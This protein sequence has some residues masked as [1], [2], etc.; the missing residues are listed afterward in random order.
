MKKK[1]LVMG[2]TLFLLAVIF[3]GCTQEDK[4]KNLGYANNGK[5]FGFNPPSGWSKTE[6]GKLGSYDYDVKFSNVAEPENSVFIVAFIDK[7][8]SGE[9]MNKIAQDIITVL[10]ASPSLSNISSTPRTVNGMDAYEINL[11]GVTGEPLMKFMLIKNG[12]NVLTLIYS[13]WSNLCNTYLSD[14]EQCVNSAII[15]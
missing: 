1:L 10:E 12:N 4:L 8:N 9:G 15:V 6:N 7:Y 11:T 13:A 5:G 14:F 2:V 3:S